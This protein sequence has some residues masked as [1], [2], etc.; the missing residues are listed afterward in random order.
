M[1]STKRTAGGASPFGDPHRRPR[2]D[3]RAVALVQT[4]SVDSTERGRQRLGRMEAVLDA[5]YLLT[6]RK[7][8]MAFA[9]PLAERLQWSEAEILDAI[10]DLVER[11]L[12]EYETTGP[13]ISLTQRGTDLAEQRL[14]AQGRDEDRAL[15]AMRQAARLSFLRYAYDATDARTGEPFNFRDAAAATGV[16]DEQELAAAADWLVDRG[17]LSWFAIGGSIVITADGVDEIEQA[18]SAPDESS[19]PGLPP[20]NVLV[21]ANSPGAIVQQG[22]TSST[23]TIHYDSTNLDLIRA[24]LASFEARLDDLS[25]DA[26]TLREVG[27][28]LASANAHAALENPKS[29]ILRASLEELKAFLIAAAASGV[30]QAM[31]TALLKSWPG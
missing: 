29:G 28:S 27:A 2:R 8:S 9:G 18:R 11:D 23:I 13:S 19:T 6:G 16:T 26:A 14:L 3:A 17:L 5:T 4:H 12:A 31:A 20:Y 25:F 7:W 1:R 21:V 30:G 10:D 22:T 15:V 24:W